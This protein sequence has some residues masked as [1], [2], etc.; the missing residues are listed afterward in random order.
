VGTDWQSGQDIVWFIDVSSRAP[1]LA[2]V[3]VMAWL[4]TYPRSGTMAN[5][6]LA[7]TGGLLAAFNPIIGLSVAAVLLAAVILYRMAEARFSLPP[8]D[9][10]RFTS[11]SLFFFGGALLAWPAFGHMFGVGQTV[12]LSYGSW[13]LIKAAAIIAG[14]LVL[15]PLAVLGALRA[16]REVRPAIVMLTVASCLLIV[17]VPFVELYEVNQHNFVNAASCLLAIPATAWIM[18]QPNMARRRAARVIAIFLP[19]TLCLAFAFSGRGALPVTFAQTLIRRT[20]VDSPLESLYTWL[21]SSTDRDAVLIVDPARPVKM[22]GNVSEMPA[23]TGRALFVDHLTYMT[24]PYR[25]R[26][27]RTAIS[28]DASRGATLGP[29]ASAYIRAL[30]RPCY[31]VVFNANDTAA[32]ARIEKSLGAPVFRQ[33]FVA[34]FRLPLDR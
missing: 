21:R 23:L 30:G 3:M 33:D 2:L 29:D 4:F 16:P 24:A 5:F 25:D 13:M 12:E 34:A 11:R 28:A 31:V 6:G 26:V 22:A 32:I 10:G 7:A 15:L 8:M 18:E 27:L 20:P 19:S 17:V 9:R 14:F 1:A